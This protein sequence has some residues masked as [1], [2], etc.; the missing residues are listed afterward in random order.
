[1]CT[2]TFLVILATFNHHAFKA[3]FLACDAST[4]YLHNHVTYDQVVRETPI[5]HHQQE[6]IVTDKVIPQLHKQDKW[7]KQDLDS[8]DEAIQITKI[9]DIDLVQN[10]TCTN[11][12]MAKH[13]WGACSQ[14]PVNQ[15]MQ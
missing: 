14:N 4:P 5:I 15:S 1:M 6:L 8:D 2:P 12:P 9:A 11:H 7:D 3:A 10:Y 13:M